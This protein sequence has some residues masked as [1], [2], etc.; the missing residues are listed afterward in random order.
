MRGH[1]AYYWRCPSIFKGTKIDQWQDGYPNVLAI[2][3]DISNGESYLVIDSDGAVVA[4]SMFTSNPE[5]TYADIDGKW[6]TPQ[7]LAYG[8]IHRMAIAQAHRKLGIAQFMIDQFERKL[9]AQN[10]ASLKIDTHKDNIGM[11]KLLTKLG[12]GYCGVITLR[13]GDLRLGF[14]KVL[15]LVSP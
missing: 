7:G 2:E 12:Y 14:E 5:S 8:V 1:Y 9:I 10:I 6:I 13:S 3:N 11:Q 15:G 4:T